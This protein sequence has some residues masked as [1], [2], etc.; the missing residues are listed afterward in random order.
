[1]RF[2]EHGDYT[3]EVNPAGEALVEDLARRLRSGAMLLI[4]YGFPAR[5]YYH[6]QRSMGTLVCHYRHRSHDDPFFYPGLS[7]ITAHV[8]FSAVAQAG[9]RGGLHV[10][11]FCPQ[12]AF[13]LGCGILELLGAVAPPESFKYMK[14]AAQVQQLISPAEMGELFKVLA[15]ARSRDVAW[16]GFALA[17][18]RDR[19]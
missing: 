13:L 12:A 7:D 14:A 17:D 9:V 4:D 1:V 19:L 16:P 11:G 2:P 6:P 18:H 10:A 3:S 5:E 15:L 8:D